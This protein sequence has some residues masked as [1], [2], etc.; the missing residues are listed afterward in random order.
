MIVEKL[1]FSRTPSRVALMRLIRQRSRGLVIPNRYNKE[2]EISIAT[3]RFSR[4][5]RGRF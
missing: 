3:G 1:R 5:S 4:H 2:S